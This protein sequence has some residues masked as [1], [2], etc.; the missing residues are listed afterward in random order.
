LTA[1]KLTDEETREI[2]GAWFKVVE[3][4]NDKKVAV[5]FRLE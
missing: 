1:R 5:V 2:P 3:D 4:L